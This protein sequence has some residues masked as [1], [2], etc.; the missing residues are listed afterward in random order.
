MGNH[1]Q[2]K[3]DDIDF[4]AGANAILATGLNLLNGVDLADAVSMIHSSSYYIEIEEGIEISLKDEMSYR[5]I[6]ILNGLVP[7]ESFDASYDNPAL[8]YAL[9]VFEKVRIELEC[10][11]SV[12]D[13]YFR[14]K[15]LYSLLI[16]FH[17]ENANDESNYED[18]ANEILST[19]RDSNVVSNIPSA[20]PFDYVM[21]RRP[22]D[23]MKDDRKMRFFI[24]FKP[25]L[26]DMD[27]MGTLIID[28]DRRTLLWEG[29]SLESGR[30]REAVEAVFGYLCAQVRAA[31][32]K[33]G[34]PFEG[35][36]ALPPNGVERLFERETKELPQ[37][38]VDD[39]IRKLRHKIRGYRPANI[40]YSGLVPRWKRTSDSDAHIFTVEI[41]KNVPVS[42]PEFWD[43]NKEDY[44]CSDVATEV[45]EL[46]FD[47]MGSGVEYVH[48]EVVFV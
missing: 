18:K 15:N 46:L 19:I 35:L 24:G 3:L 4:C 11:G 16:G 22:F 26:Q 42:I 1:K 30:E 8:H 44:I 25:P 14:K 41:P 17:E 36:V 43:W 21:F 9:K 5:T 31:G 39:T 45:K 23:F 20:S 28:I 47:V 7:S 37:E 38:I 34:I 13:V 12:L 40:S 6:C 33:Q 29:K 2:Y 27:R 10:R 48:T 32:G